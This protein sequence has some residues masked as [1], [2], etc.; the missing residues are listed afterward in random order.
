MLEVLGEEVFSEEMVFQ[1][2]KVVWDTPAL[3]AFDN[4]ELSDLQ[5]IVVC[6]SFGVFTPKV[7]CLSHSVSF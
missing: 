3:T 5:I 2:L 7:V 6:F 4:V 1:L